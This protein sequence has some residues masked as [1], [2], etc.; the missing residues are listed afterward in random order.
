MITLRPSF[1]RL[2]VEVLRRFEN[3]P[4]AD[5][6]DAMGGSGAIDYRIGSLFS[7][8]AFVGSALTVQTPPN[9]NLSPF[10]ALDLVHPGDVVMIS[11]RDF[12]AGATIGDTLLAFYQR[13]GDA[14]SSLS[15]SMV[16]CETSPA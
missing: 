5:I 9:D 16:L 8:N 4:T 10:I 7:A 14:E 2:G 13:R 12:T 6:V 11:T 15:S 3:I 1:E